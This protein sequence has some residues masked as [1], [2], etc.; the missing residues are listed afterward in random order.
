MPWLE[1]TFEVDPDGQE[2]TLG[3]LSDLP[4]SMFEEKDHGLCAYLDAREWTLELEACLQSLPFANWRAYTVREL[5][6]ENWNQRW[7]E[8]FEPV[9]L[10]PFC[11]IRAVF[12]PPIEDVKHELVIQPEMAFGTGHHAT[13][14]LMLLGMQKLDFE[15][16]R[17]LDFGAGTAILGML[18]AR[19]GAAHVSAVE[20]EPPACESAR[21]NVRRNQLEDRVFVIE[22]DRHVI[23][24]PAYDILLANINRNVLMAEL[25]TLNQ[26]M[27]PGAIAGLSGFLTQDAIAMEKSG[28]DLGW[29]LLSHDTDTDWM[30]QWWQKPLT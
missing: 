9:I 23:P 16:K 1:V 20:I 5:P 25:G 4:F 29:K 19:L 12:H 6:D 14:K 8:N 13:T 26:F 11:A 3:L 21:H 30:V 24:G 27:H 17:V 28:F 15:G 7:E 18:A 2:I 10:R 22:G